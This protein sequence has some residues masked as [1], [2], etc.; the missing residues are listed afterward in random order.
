MATHGIS[1]DEAFALLSAA[2]QR[3]NRKLHDIATGIVS[4]ETAPPSS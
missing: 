3:L 4:G 1:N 2:S